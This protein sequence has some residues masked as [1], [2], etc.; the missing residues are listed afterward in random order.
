MNKDELKKVFEYQLELLEKIPAFEGRSESF[1]EGV[2]RD[3][4]DYLESTKPKKIYSIEI[5][6]STGDSFDTNITSEIIGLSWDSLEK[7]ERNIKYIEEHDKFLSSYKYSSTTNKRDKVLSESS[8]K[9]WFVPET[10]NKY[11]VNIFKRSIF[12]EMN[13]GKK[14]QLST[15][16]EGQFEKLI[17]C[18]IIELEYPD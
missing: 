13:S 8:F 9:Y 11:L 5:K 17:E 2:L 12:L 10:D 4:D 14:F 6:Y 16:W 15:F 7:V 1:I 3:Y 18:N